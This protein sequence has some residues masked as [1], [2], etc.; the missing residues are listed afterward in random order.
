MP[1]DRLPNAL[2]D[3]GV[4][5]EAEVNRLVQANDAL[6]SPQIALWF[7]GNTAWFTLPGVDEDL[8]L[9]R[10]HL[11]LLAALVSSLNEHW[12]S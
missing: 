5:L 7:E 9:E 2:A 12:A 10:E 1:P 8:S 11:P 6:G 3:P 4:A